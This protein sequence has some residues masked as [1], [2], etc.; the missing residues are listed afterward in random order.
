MQVILH[1]CRFCERYLQPPSTWVACSL[2]SRELLA[3]CL[4]KLKGL[5]KVI[6]SL[7]YIHCKYIYLYV[8]HIFWQSLTL[9]VNLGDIT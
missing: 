1:F 3:L 4:K 7:L 5:N 9:V 8:V 6:S 2:E